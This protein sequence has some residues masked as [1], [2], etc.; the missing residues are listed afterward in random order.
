M[1]DCNAQA[2]GMSGGARKQFMSSCLSG[3]TTKA[4]HCVT[5]KPCGN[6]CIAKDEVCHK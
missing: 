2:T 3:G 4:P 6:T 1:K 5:G